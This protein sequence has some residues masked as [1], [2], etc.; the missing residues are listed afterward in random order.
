MEKL[1]I[2]S[3]SSATCVTLTQG[4]DKGDYKHILEIIDEELTKID[5]SLANNFKMNFVVDYNNLYQINVEKKFF[6]N[7][8]DASFALLI[9]EYYNDNVQLKCILDVNSHTIFFLNVNFLNGIYDEANYIDL[10]NLYFNYL[11]IS[12]GH[13]DTILTDKSILL[14]CLSGSYMHFNRF[15]YDDFM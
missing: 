14:D 5:G 7:G 3:D 2:L 15:F 6:S 9:F 1:E 13:V 8:N 4:I 11:G 12:D 10:S